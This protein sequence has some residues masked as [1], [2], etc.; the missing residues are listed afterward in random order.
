MRDEVLRSSS[1]RLLKLSQEAQ[2]G[3]AASHVGSISRLTA[4]YIESLQK[5]GHMST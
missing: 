3:K 1:L 5:S 2:S 4:V